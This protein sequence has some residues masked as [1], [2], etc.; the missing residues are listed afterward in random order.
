MIE[1]D[2]IM[3]DDL[4]IPLELMMEHAGLNFARL[5]LRL[6]EPDSQTFRI[7][8]GSGSNGGGGLVA[9]RKL[10]SWGYE[11][12]ILLPRGRASLRKVPSLQIQR[13]ESVGVDV[14]DGIPDLTPDRDL[15]I[16]DAYLGYG[17]KPRED[18]ITERVFTYLRTE[19]NV[20]SL[21]VP[22]GQDSTSGESY[23]QL[24]PIATMSIAFLKSGLLNSS[25][26]F[27]G[28]LYVADI[29][30]PKDV[31]L[32]KLNLSWN[33][34]YSINDLDLLYSAFAENPLQKAIISESSWRLEKQF[35]VI[36]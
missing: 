9:A 34:P 17:F 10:K 29:G 22:S 18:E 12:E 30:V 8:S 20:I 13:A 16:L 5:A 26:T 19:S 14:I 27:V 24:K 36:S 25:Q 7:V 4:E 15:S 6:T 1:V 21:D 23:S 31:Y 35:E 2:R 28:D 32:S 33:E 11:T 3:I